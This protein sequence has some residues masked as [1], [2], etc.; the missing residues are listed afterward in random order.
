MYT[1]VKGRVRNAAP[2][3]RNKPLYALYEAIINSIQAIEEKQ[4]KN[5][6]I[7]IYIKRDNRQLS[8]DN[9]G[10]LPEIYGFEI[11]DNGIGFNEENYKSFNISDTLKKIHLGGRGIGRFAYL[12]A[13]E[14]AEIKSVYKEN[15]QWHKRLF[16]FAATEEGIEHHRMAELPKGPA[17]TSVNLVNFLSSMREKCSRSALNIAQQILSH[18]TQYFL[19]KNC[20][21]ITLIDN[22]PDSEPISLNLLWEKEIGSQ[23]E[24]F[25]FKLKNRKFGVTLLKKHYSKGAAEHRVFLCA[26]G[27]EVDSYKLNRMIPQLKNKLVDP[28]T[29][30]YFSVAAYVNSKYLDEMV[31]PERTGFSF[32]DLIPQDGLD[33]NDL[34]YSQEIL[35]ACQQEIEKALKPFLEPL[36]EQ[37][38]QR[39]EQYIHQQEPAYKTLLKEEYK[40]ELQQLP[41]SLSESELHD[42]LHRLRQNL[43]QTVTRFHQNFQESSDNVQPE[44][45]SLALDW[46][47]KVQD[48]SQINL[49]EYLQ[50]RQ[51]LLELVNQN[52][53]QD[54][55]KNFSLYETL[56]LNPKSK[57]PQNLWILDER[58]AFFKTMT[59]FALDNQSQLWLAVDY[60]NPIETVS[61]LQFIR[62]ETQINDLIKT[63]FQWTNSLKN[64]AVKLPWNLE[65]SKDVKFGACILIDNLH[66]LEE[67][68]EPYQLSP[69]PDRMGLTGRKD[70]LNLDFNVFDY[71]K[72]LH[73]A[74]KRNQS[75]LEVQFE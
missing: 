13:F 65:L 75:L 66:K 12:V 16:E 62:P 31:H 20:P 64:G 46:L 25:Y 8:L 49:N 1:N 19:D 50:N 71:R 47:S 24:Q 15:G 74:L 38:Y 59:S 48:L 39:V 10:H 9:I 4:E 5:G 2:A 63:L 37:A 14:R 70:S 41:A 52:I 35:N 45:N 34:I 21:Q 61:L 3:L 17:T 26:N 58:L 40:D 57:V 22:L 69:T 67:Y 23:K 11:I 72:V 6:K 42:E 7:N 60:L 44:D 29:N 43:E 27:R 33:L 18:C 51:I 36:E 56:F 68:Y 73:D 32:P 55:E 30:Q 54:E 53:S 28:A